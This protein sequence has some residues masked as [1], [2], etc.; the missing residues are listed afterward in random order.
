MSQKASLLTLV[1]K[2][3]VPDVSKSDSSE[4]EYE[5]LG[6]SD[7]DDH[8]S[9]DEST[10]PDDDKSVD[11]NKTDD[12]EGDEF[13][14]TPDDYVPTDDENVDD[15]E[16]ERI[17]KKMYDDVNVELKD[18]EPDNEE[19]GDEE[20]THAEKYIRK[21]KIE[22]ACKQQET[23]YTVTSS[24][25]VEL[26]EFDQKMALFEIMTKT[27]SFNKNTK[28]KALYHALMESILE[29]EDAM[30][31]GVADKS[32][33]RKPDDADRDEGPPV[34]PNQ[35]LKRKKTGKDDEPSKKVK[36]IESSKGTT[37]SQP[38]STGK[39]AQAEKI[40]FEAGDT[41]VPHDL[42]EDMGNTDEPPVVKADPKDW[43]KKPERPSTSDSRME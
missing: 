21:V 27:K 33:K 6:D 43:F 32:K 17:N 5:S 14:H 30:D 10:K 12:E 3:R 36:S 35:G 34:R 11:L 26:Q 22:Q 24:D 4:S 20:T 19:K 41:Q 38:K 8:Q 28:H 2:L 31:K 23:R 9:D 18:V 1:L 40:V 16:Y 39:Y 42:K 7:D 25:S 37:K 13:V 15:E 29:D